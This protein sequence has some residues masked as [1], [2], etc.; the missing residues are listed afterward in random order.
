MQSHYGDAQLPIGNS[1]HE[2]TQNQ[3]RNDKSDNRPMQG[4]RKC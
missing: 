4:N 1:F 3:V 2:R